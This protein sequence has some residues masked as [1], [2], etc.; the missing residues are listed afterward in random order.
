MSRY[1]LSRIEASADIEVH[2]HTE[3]AELRG[4][5]RLT[6]VTVEHNQTLER[7]QM[8]V[9]GVF[10]F[11]GA[12]PY[13]EWLQ[14]TLKLDERGFILTGEQVNDVNALFETSLP[15]VFRSGR[16]A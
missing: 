7:S 2:H 8:D 12:L 14:G 6:G 16:R 11:I 3:V 15:D 4:D 9:S 5:A 13:T 10:T 1:L